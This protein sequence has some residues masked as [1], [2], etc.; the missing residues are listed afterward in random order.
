MEEDDTDNIEKLCA[1]VPSLQGYYKIIGQRASV[2]VTTKDYFPLVGALS[3][4]LYISTGHGSHG[5]LSSLMSA[6]ILS[7]MFSD[8]SQSLSSDVISALS[9]D[10]FKD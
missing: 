1:A 8:K 4:N 3:D 2:R 10:R 5:I 7:N 6:D 9:P